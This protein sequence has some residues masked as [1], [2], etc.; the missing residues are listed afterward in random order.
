MKAAWVF[1][2]L[3]TAMIAPAWTQEVKP[4]ASPAGEDSPYESMHVLARAMQLIR[5]DYVDDQKISYRDL[6]YAALRGMLADLDPHSAFM[7]PEDFKGMQEDTKS[8]FGGLG[9]TVTTKD[10]LITLI[11]VAEGSP[12]FEAGLQPGDQIRKINGTTTDRLGISDAVDKLRGEPGEKV[13]LTISRPATNELKEFTIA[14]AVIKVPSVVD[15]MILPESATGGR[16]VGYLRLT[17]FNE[18]TAGELAK[19]LDQLDAQGMEALVLDLR[20]N[21]GGLLG[22][23]VEVCAQFVPANTKVVSTEG[24]TPSREYATR[25]AKGAPRQYPLAILINSA[26]ASGSEIVAGA[27]KDLRR[28]ILVGETTFGKGSVQSVVA[29]PDGSA[30][31]FTTAKYFTPSRRPIHEHGVEP[32]IRCALTAEQEMRIYQ[33]RRR[34]EM[35]GLGREGSKVQDPQLDRAVDALTG[36]LLYTG[37]A[38]SPKE[39]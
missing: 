10:G 1:G 8:E 19:A 39:G 25:A 6:T 12:G 5:Q 29:L 33:A 11:G 2:W 28:A 14:R 31:R 20:F 32:D 22:S 3:A 9:V 27:L 34:K 21:P 26:S 13:T 24:R 23:A 38:L 4:A 35:P 36:V 37:R 17:Q 15:A 7:D 18:P 30:M 16:K